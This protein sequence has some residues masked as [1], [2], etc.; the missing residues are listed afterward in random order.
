MWSLRLDQVC[1]AEGEGEAAAPQEQSSEEEEEDQPRSRRRRR[2]AKPS[3]ASSD[4]LRERWQWLAA[5]K[6]EDKPWIYFAMHRA[7][8]S[9]VVSLAW[10]RSLTHKRP[11]IRKMGSLRVSEQHG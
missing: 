10:S 6:P 1:S 7:Y 3:A 4:Q 2:R 11:S 8:H 5:I 9:K